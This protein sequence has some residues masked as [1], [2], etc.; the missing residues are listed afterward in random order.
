VKLVTFPTTPA[1]KLCTPVTIDAAK[2]DPGRCGNDEPVAEGLL[3]E[4]VL[5]DGLDE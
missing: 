3:V 2:S 4:I 5:V 1:E